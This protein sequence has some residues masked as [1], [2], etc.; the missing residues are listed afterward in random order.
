MASN[1]LITDLYQLTMAN[2][3][4]KKGMHEEKSSL[5]AFTER[6]HSTAD[7]PSW[8]AFSTLSTS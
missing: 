5:T 1:G 2:A 7:T 6:T 3:L 8:P 4:F